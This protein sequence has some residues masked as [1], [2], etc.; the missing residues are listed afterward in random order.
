MVMFLI[1]LADYYGAI[2]T[3]AASK[4][5]AK[6]RLA[7]GS[8]TTPAGSPTVPPALTSDP[9]GVPNVPRNLEVLVAARRNEYGGEF[10]VVAANEMDPSGATPTALPLSRPV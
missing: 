7:L 10:S 1:L 9:A 8:P 3:S 5:P 4:L 6:V 2:R